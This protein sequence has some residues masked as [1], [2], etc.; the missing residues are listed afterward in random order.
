ML[1]VLGER[2]LSSFPRL[3]FPPDTSP[4]PFLDSISLHHPLRHLSFPLGSTTGCIQSVQWGSRWCRSCR[5]DRAVSLYHSFLPA[6]F[7]CPSVGAWQALTWLLSRFSVAPFSLLSLWQFLP[8]AIRVFTKVPTCDWWAPPWACC[9]ATRTNGVWHRAAPARTPACTLHML[10][11][12]LADSGN[13][14]KGVMG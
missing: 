8:F 7:L 11:L 6:I 12:V 13:V 3:W 4:P 9:R 2:H 10:Q 14:H 1:K 5:Q